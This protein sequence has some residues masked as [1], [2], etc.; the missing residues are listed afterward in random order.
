[1]TKKPA[2]KPA[3]LTQK[4]TDLFIR[5]ILG[6]ELAIPSRSCKRKQTALSLAEKKLVYVEENTKTCYVELTKHGRYLRFVMSQA[7]I[8][9]K[10]NGC[11]MKA[12]ETDAELEA[13]R[14][15]DNLTQ[16][17]RSL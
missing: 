15:V 3:D 1:M 2:T 11:Y 9:V 12:P 16:A 13:D 17:I 5:I 7:G 8:L 6:E 10:K 14:K 4:E